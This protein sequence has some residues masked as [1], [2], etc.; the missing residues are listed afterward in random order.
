[1]LRDRI[2]VLLV[3][4][5]EIARRV[6]LPYLLSQP[7][8]PEIL[9]T[10]RDPSVAERVAVEFGTR[11]HRGSIAS[12]R[13]Q[14]VVICTPAASHADLA[15]EALAAGMHVICEKPL[16]IAAGD[17]RRVA[18]ASRRHGR[19]VFPCYTNRYRQDVEILRDL[20]ASKRIGRIRELSAQWTRRHGVPGTQGGLAAGVLWDLG[21]HLADLALH[22]T[23]WSGEVTAFAAA[24]SPAPVDEGVAPWYGGT[25]CGESR[26]AAEN[27]AEGPAEDTVHALARV[28]GHGVVRLLV[29]WNQQGAGDE[30]CLQAVGTRG[31]AELRTVF[32]FSPDRQ[33]IEGPC[34]RVSDPRNARWQVVLDRQSREPVEYRRQLDVAYA[35]MTGADPPEAADLDVAVRSVTLCDAFARSLA[36]TSSVA[37]TLA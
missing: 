20:L 31:V 15:V 6:H 16:A 33:R 25:W 7:W 19:R 35:S 4:S 22:L 18:E 10:D 2:R 5:G 32:G 13:A 27:R 14:I 3:G 11:A 17:A 30:V 1:M 26:P 36:T 37:A 34:V 8:Q 28:A 23:G 21:S 29:S 9:V 12:A 24:A